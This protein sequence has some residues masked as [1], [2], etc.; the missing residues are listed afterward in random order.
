MKPIYMGHC[1]FVTDNPTE[2]RG[3][4]VVGITRSDCTVNVP[5]VSINILTDI[6]DTLISLDY[7]IDNLSDNL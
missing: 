4:N 7:W 5:D 1:V 3:T 6:I 2:T